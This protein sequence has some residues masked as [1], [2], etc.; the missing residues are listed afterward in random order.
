M[1]VEMST[2]VLHRGRVA[3]V[4]PKSLAASARPR[5]TSREQR[6]SSLTGYIV[7]TTRPFANVVKG[8]KGRRWTP[9][10]PNRSV[11]HPEALRSLHPRLRDSYN[12]SG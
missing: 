2:R 10:H 8:Y 1:S 11:H 6:D 4:P 5:E 3:A 7:D 9:M 12:K